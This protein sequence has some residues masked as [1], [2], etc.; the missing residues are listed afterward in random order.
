MHRNNE[1]PIVV[2]GTAYWM[3]HLI[4]PDRLVSS[5]TSAASYATRTG[6]SEEIQ[7]AISSLPPELFSLFENL[8]QD[9]PSAKLSPHEAFQLYSLLS[10]LDPDIS[11]RWHWKDTRK[12]LRNLEI[13]RETGRRPSDIILEQSTRHLNVKTRSRAL[14]HHCSLVLT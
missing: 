2:G 4:F 3:Q 12:V 7:P 1:L 5:Q 9:A 10:A 8:P 13:I 14:T 6:W 11:R